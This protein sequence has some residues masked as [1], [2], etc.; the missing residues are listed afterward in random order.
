MPRT[1]FDPEQM[2]P[3][4]PLSFHIL[5]ALADA[6]RHGYGIIKEVEGA[7][8][9]APGTPEAHALTYIDFVEAAKRLLRENAQSIVLPYDGVN[10]Q[11]PTYC[12]LKPYHLDVQ[13]SYFDHLEAGA[14]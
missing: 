12:Y 7:E 4:T 11:P 14:L 13:T 2:L 9:I 1:R 3:L 5:L 8:G 10:P 6:D